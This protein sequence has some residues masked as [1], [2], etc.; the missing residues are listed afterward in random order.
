M[1]EIVQ[2]VVIFLQKKSQVG[3]KKSQNPVLRTPIHPT[4]RV[5]DFFL[6]PLVYLLNIITSYAKSAKSHGFQ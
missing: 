6:T 3:R 4:I 1:V 2:K 5:R